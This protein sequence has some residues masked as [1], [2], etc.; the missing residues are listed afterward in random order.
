MNLT[1]PWLSGFRCSAPSSRTQK[2]TL[3]RPSEI[4]FTAKITEA[5]LRQRL[6]DEVLE[7]IGA[8]SDDGKPA[9]GV[10]TTVRRGEGRSGGYTVEVS[11]PAPARVSLPK[12]AAG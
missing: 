8:L 2:E 1:T 3:L 10:T 5:E 12:P 9:P 6:I 7:S 4:R 11:G